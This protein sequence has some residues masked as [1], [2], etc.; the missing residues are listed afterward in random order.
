MSY[1]VLTEFERLFL[2]KPYR[3]RDSSRGDFVAMHLFEDLVTLNRS[4][5]L[6]PRVQTRQHVLGTTNLAHGIRARRGD[7]TFGEV[8][9]HTI[10]V[11][12]PGYAV[13][14]GNVATIEIGVETKILAKAM[15]KQVD[16]VMTS[17][18]Q[19]IAEFRRGGSTPICVALVGINYAP[20]AVSY[21]G[22]RE[23]WT[24]GRSNRHPIQEAAEAENRIFQ[25]VGPLY[26]EL[27][28]LKYL[29]T[30]APPFQF[31]WLNAAQT[32]QDYGSA[33][34]RISRK[35]DARF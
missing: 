10:P 32:D 19:Q 17:L 13:A 20:I 35:Y 2:G 15:I 27:V 22:D 26:D 34:V 5:K 25:K 4:T 18:G 14:R 1:R 3:H 7:G 23:F 21:E 29:A 24:D 30:N 11:P 9:P 8:V 31:Q 6:S 33:L 28:F 12:D 16:R